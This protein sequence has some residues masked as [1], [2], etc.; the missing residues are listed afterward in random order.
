MEFDGKR[1]L[2]TV[3][4][5]APLPGTSNRPRRKSFSYNLN[6]DRVFINKGLASEGV[7]RGE[8]YGKIM[9]KL[10]EAD[11]DL[12]RSVELP[13]VMDMLED[14]KDQNKV[15]SNLP[16]TYVNEEKASVFN[17]LILIF[18]VIL[19]IYGFWFYNKHGIT[20]IPLL[21]YYLLEFY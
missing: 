19:L 9:D 5:Q 13:V 14:K 7:P 21:H 1:M 8:A 16:S 3:Q 6:Q 17:S 11:P 20:I 15:I 12:V 18:F 4:K 10:R 2:V